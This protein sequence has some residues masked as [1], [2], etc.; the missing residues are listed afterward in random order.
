MK[1]TWDRR[2]AQPAETCARAEDLVAYLYGEASR[3]E[4]L[5]FEKHM[6]RCASCR[7]ELSAF[8]NMREAIGEW[9]ELAIGT[10]ASPASETKAPLAA[11][12]TFEPSPRRR[13]AFAAL[14]QFFTLSPA[15]MRAA[16]AAVALI[17]CALVAIAVAHFTQQPQTIVV[18]KPVQTGYSEEQLKE[19][20][21]YALRQQNED[22]ALPTPAPLPQEKIAQ[23]TP[24][25]ATQPS[26]NSSQVVANKVRHQV[27]PRKLTGPS[28]ELVRADDYLPFTAAKDDEKLP[29]LSDLVSDD[30]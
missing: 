4:T 30:N 17:F 6:E 8:G 22:R 26:R 5:D 23:K 12:Q 20:I 16:T 29:T 21:A 13:S 2:V 9:R 15:W 10:S 14:R 24:V 19:K 7:A 1:E 18:V 25:V 3:T 27:T 28:T 11:A